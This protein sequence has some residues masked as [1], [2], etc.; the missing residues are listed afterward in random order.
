[1]TGEGGQYVNVYGRRGGRGARPYLIVLKL[2]CVAGFVGGLLTVLAVALTGP[3]PTSERDWRER[4]E[5]VG[6]A[7]RWVIVPGV[8]GAEIVGF[9]LV[10]SIWRVMIRMRW[11]IV[12]M[13]L[14]LLCM[15]ALH[16]LMSGWLSDLRLFASVT[17]D[18]SRAAEVHGR[19]LAGASLA[20]ALGIALVI[21]GRIKPRLG[22]DYGRTFGAS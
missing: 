7:F 12:K 19:L 14:V 21:L 3:G 20:L 18:L 9:L 16:F 6:K 5:F 11:F 4:V 17:P 13:A 15:P 2:I 1:M 10:S 22:Q 8:T